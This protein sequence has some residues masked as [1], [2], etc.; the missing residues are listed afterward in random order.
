MDFVYGTVNNL[1]AM[2]LKW[3]EEGGAI[4]LVLLVVLFIVK[5]AQAVL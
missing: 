4:L 1:I 3:L 2:R 5:L